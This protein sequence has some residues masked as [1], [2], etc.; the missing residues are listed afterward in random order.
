MVGW[1]VVILPLPLAQASKQA[2]SLIKTHSI[3][4][5]VRVDHQGPRPPN[6]VIFA[7]QFLQLVYR[8]P[9]SKSGSRPRFQRSKNLRSN[10][11]GLCI[12]LSLGDYEFN[13]AITVL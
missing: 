3:K 11:L 8:S 4:P 5:G 12:D 9:G 1:G 7:Q 13:C 6:P 2:K 10:F